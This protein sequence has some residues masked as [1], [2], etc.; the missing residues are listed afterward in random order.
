MQFE[1][2]LLNLNPRSL[3]RLLRDVEISDIINTLKGASGKL[4]VFMIENVSRTVAL[5]IIDELGESRQMPSQQIVSS[6]KRILEIMKKL[7]ANGEII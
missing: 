5:L 1:E 6:Q 4:Q 3:Q 2:P 7:R